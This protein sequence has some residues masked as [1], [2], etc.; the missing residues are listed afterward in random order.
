MRRDRTWCRVLRHLAESKDPWDRRVSAAAAL[1]RV[2]L[3]GDVEAGL[4]IC[5]LLMRERA[6]LVQEAVAALLRESL[7]ADEEETRAFLDR[8]R[9]EGRPDIFDAVLG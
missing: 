6:P 9:R 7:D 8:W 3:M 4:S 2:R 5:E 1:P